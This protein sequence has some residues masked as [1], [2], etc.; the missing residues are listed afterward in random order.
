MPLKPLR[1]LLCLLWPC[2]ATAQTIP[3]IAAQVAA[4]IS[5]LLPPH[6][7]VS[8]DFQ[9]L[10]ALSAAESSAFRSALEAETKKTGIQTPGTAQPDAQVRVAISQ[11]IHGVMIVGEVRTAERQQT[12]FLPWTLPPT[13]A[14]SPRLKLE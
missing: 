9:N 12:F 13:G 7:T 10:S 2:F 6:A 8:F 4:R 3:E 14:K 11:N 1:I 5:S